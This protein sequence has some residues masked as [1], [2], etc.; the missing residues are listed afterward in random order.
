MIIVTGAAGFIGANTVK[1]LNQRGVRDVLAVD[2]LTRA[3]KFHNLVDC[4]VADYMD[5]RD[6]LE[7]L[8]KRT[9]PRADAAFHQGACSDTM[10]SDGRYVMDNNYRYSRRATALVPRNRRCRWSMRRQAPCTD[11]GRCS[12][13]G[14]T[15]SI[16]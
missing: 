12:S 8:R 5:K 3:D 14:A 16:R 10:A 6:F 15:A 4:D 1:A 7:A 2:D 9:M 13:S 11:W